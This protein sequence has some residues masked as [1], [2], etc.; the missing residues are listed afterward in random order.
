M[1]ES[2]VGRKLTLHRPIIIPALTL[3]T[4]AVITPLTNVVAILIPVVVTQ[5]V[6]LKATVVVQVVA[7]AQAHHQVHHLI[8]VPI[9]LVAQAVVEVE[10]EVEVEV[11]QEALE[12]PDRI[13]PVLKAN[14]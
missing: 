11:L 5:H 12:I 1:P 3:A 10:V 4:N 13:M 9:H 14:R 6:I 2:L 8:Q 7:A